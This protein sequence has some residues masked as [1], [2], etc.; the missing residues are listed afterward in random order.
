MATIYE[1]A[2]RAGVS[3][4]TVS[5]VLSN[6][7]Y[8]SAATRARVEQAIADLAYVPNKVAR[9]L[10][11]GRV[12]ILGL[13]VPWDPNQIFADPHLLEIIHGVEHAANQHDYNLL[14]STARRRAD[15]ASACER[16]LRGNIL[17]AAIV[18]ETLSLQEQSAALAQQPYPW[19]VVGYPI[20]GTR[21]AIHA[22]DYHGAMDA[23]RYLL[24]LGHRRIGVVSSVQRP[25]ALDE[26]V[27]GVQAAFAE[28]G[29]PFDESLLLVMDD[30]GADD[31]YTA[32][33]V[34]LRRPNPP[35]AIFALTDRL[36]LGVLRYAHEHS[37]S[38][39]GSL[40]LVGFD[41]IALVAH[42]SPPLTTVRQAGFALGEAA[43]R[44][45]FAL[46]DGDEPPHDRVLPT[47]LIVRGSTAAPPERR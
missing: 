1:V 14:L 45:V 18:V 20:T 10:T 6:K 30:L 32:G 44:A 3:P 17:D 36:A 25:T 29:L 42:A 40:S 28:A 46:L 13:L 43:A 9:G 41:D 7:P 37:I 26:R 15:A 2:N 39:P 4:A 12:F 11:T 21:A 24:G 5:K 35:S 19:V 22:D 27:R 47:E 31:G 33:A 8:V 16:W 34:L 38:V 23:T